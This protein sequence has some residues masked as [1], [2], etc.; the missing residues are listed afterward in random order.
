MA[1]DNPNFPIATAA[2]NWFD[3]SKQLHMRVYTCDGYN[4]I[5]RVNDGSGWSNGAFSAPGSAVSA[6]CWMADNGIN[7]RV[8]C[9]FE[10][11][12]TEWCATPGNANWTKG[13]YTTT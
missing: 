12:T 4:V 9:T 7:I 5:E 11:Q 1:G 8:Y 6:T 10:D 2:I 13:D 3:S